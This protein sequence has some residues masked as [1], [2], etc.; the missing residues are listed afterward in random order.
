MLMVCMVSFVSGIRKGL[1]PLDGCVWLWR[2]VVA[3]SVYC[4]NLGENPVSDLLKDRPLD[5]LDCSCHRVDG[6][7]G[8]DD[9]RPIV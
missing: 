9:Y 1:L 8:T 7:H 5:L 3:N 4:R 2:E 6:V